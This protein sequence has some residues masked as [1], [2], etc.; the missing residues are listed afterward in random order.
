MQSGRRV[1]TKGTECREFRAISTYFI[2]DV[3]CKIFM[4]ILAKRTVTYL[5]SNGSVDESVQKAGVPGI[6]GCI[7]HASTI[8]DA[9]QE[10]KKKPTKV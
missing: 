10:A 5:Q 9:I 8:R 3:A 7:E 1:P 6:P 2:I 4:G